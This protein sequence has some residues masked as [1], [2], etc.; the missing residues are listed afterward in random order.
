MSA[1]GSAPDRAGGRVTAT[2]QR[3][4]VTLVAAVMIALAGVA[5]GMVAGYSLA[6]SH[7]RDAQAE[8]TRARQELS[9]L[10]QAHE[11]LQERNWMLFLQ[12]QETSPGA[13]PA[14]PPADG[15]FTEGIYLVGTDIEAGTYRGEVTGELGYWARLNATNGMVSA[16]EANDVVR[17][18]F[19]LTILPRDEAVELRGVT[20]SAS[21]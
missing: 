6:L 7:A 8:A 17:G 18:P 4:T 12:T 14:G 21:E 19:V 9:Q 5:L 10:A 20:L 3:R 16:I 1:D 11:K 13:P 2:G 15:V